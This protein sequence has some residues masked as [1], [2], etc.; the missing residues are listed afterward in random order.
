[1]GD[2]D[3]IA[4]QQSLRNAER[5]AAAEALNIPPWRLPQDPEQ[6]RLRKLSVN[7][8]SGCDGG[9]LVRYCPLHGLNGSAVR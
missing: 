5:M 3:V 6:E 7:E 2:I 1:M 4:A 8:C 9:R